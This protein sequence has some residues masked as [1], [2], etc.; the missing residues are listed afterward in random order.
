MPDRHHKD[1][2]TKYGDRDQ[3]GK[4]GGNNPAEGEAG[5]RTAHKRGDG[6]GGG[7]NPGTGNH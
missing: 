5:G 1:D 2:G 3:A 4:G 7:V 6:A